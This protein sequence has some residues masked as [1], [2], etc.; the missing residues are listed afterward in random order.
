MAKMGMRKNASNKKVIGVA[1]E[2]LCC[3]VFDFD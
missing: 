1:K 2:L 3:F